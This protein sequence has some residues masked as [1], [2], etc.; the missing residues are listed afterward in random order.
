MSAPLALLF[1]LV[2]DV[3]VVEL[4][5]VLVA[6]QSDPVWKGVA[7]VREGFNESITQNGLSQCSCV[8]FRIVKNDLRGI[9][10]RLDALRLPR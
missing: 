4:F 3:F 7:D 1:L 10:G 8:D 2:F 5:G 9:G 6:V